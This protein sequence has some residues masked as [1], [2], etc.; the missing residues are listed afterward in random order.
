MMHTMKTTDGK[1]AA[2]DTQYV[3]GVHPSSDGYCIMIRKGSG[4]HDTIYVETSKEEA[5]KLVAAINDAKGV[6]FA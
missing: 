2:F 4:D 1:T 6:K 5:D 3:V